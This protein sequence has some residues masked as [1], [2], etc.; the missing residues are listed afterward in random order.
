ML[1]STDSVCLQASFSTEQ[2]QNEE[3]KRRT[4]LPLANLILLGRTLLCGCDPSGSPLLRT[5]IH[6]ARR[7]FALDKIKTASTKA[8]AVVA[9]G[10]SFLPCPVRT[11]LTKEP[12]RLRSKHAVTL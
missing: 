10:L 8:P 7:A 11:L 12:E 5:P 4:K 3:S 6:K 2:K 9:L 1:S